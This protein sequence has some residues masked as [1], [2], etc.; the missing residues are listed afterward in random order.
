MEKKAQAQ[1]SHM[2]N[3]P[4]TNGTNVTQSAHQVHQGMGN[5]R[6]QNQQPQTYLSNPMNRNL[7]GH[8]DHMDHREKMTKFM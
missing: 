1:S 4:A 3:V 6:W 5:G 8:R 7:Q 2:I